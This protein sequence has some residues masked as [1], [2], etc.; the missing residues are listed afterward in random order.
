M[1]TL[2]RKT[3][4]LY[5]ICNFGWS[6]AFYNVN[7]P[8]NYFYFPNI[9]KGTSMFPVFIPQRG[10]LLGL[11][12]LAFIIALGIFGILPFAIIGVFMLSGGYS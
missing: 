7:N 8:L 3:L 5:G 9:E 11:T 10:I 1:K 6:L 12:F 4:A 2:S